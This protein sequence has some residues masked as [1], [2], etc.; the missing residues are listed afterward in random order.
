MQVSRHDLFQIAVAQFAEDQTQFAVGLAEFSAGGESLNGRQGLRRA[1]EAKAN[2]ARELWVQ[3]QELDHMLRLDPADVN[4]LVRLVS[5]ATAQ[6]GPP[7]KVGQREVG[8]AVEVVQEV[9]LDIEDA[10]CLFGALEVFAELDELP[11]FVVVKRGVANALKETTAA[12]DGLIV[13][14]GRIAGQTAEVRVA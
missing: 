2:R 9:I 3:Q 8:R 13:F 4:A 5:P 11:A 6:D 7:Q 14:V 10:Q 12:F 1:L